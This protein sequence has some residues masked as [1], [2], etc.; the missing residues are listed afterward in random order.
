MS[1]SRFA[2]R[3]EGVRKCFARGRS[4]KSVYRAARHLL[5]SGWSPDGALVALDEVNVTLSPGEK[6]AVIGDNG[7]GKTTLLR[8]V[9][10]LYLPTRGRVDVSGDLVLVAG[11]GL[12]MVEELSVED[13]VL[14][15]GAIHGLERREVK[16]RLPDIVEWADLGDV[17]QAPLRT[18]SSGMRTRL[19]FSVM[20]HAVGDVYLLDEALTAGDRHFKAKCEDALAVYR[21]SAKTFIVATHDVEFARRFADRVLWL[22]KGRQ[23]ALGTPSDVVDQYTSMR[24]EP[25]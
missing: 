23:M 4:V 8:T 5:S 7:A 20:R 3:V 25:R 10:G 16:A 6:L 14:L 13:N 2:V 18:L 19:A 21:Q 1:S 24:A 12:G 22:Q 17:R 11:L 9:A 15:H